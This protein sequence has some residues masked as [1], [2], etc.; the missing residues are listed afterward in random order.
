MKSSSK[1]DE[2]CVPLTMRKQKSNVI[3]RHEVFFFEKDTLLNYFQG[4]PSHMVIEKEFKIIN[5]V[6][7]RF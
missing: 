3:R 5:N 6:K 7:K 2:I 4:Q 1:E